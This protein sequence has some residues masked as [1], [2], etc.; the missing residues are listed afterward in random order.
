MRFTKVD[1]TCPNTTSLEVDSNLGASGPSALLTLTARVWARGLRGL[2]LGC[3]SRVPLSREAGARLAPN[4]LPSAA[5][6]SSAGLPA[7]R[8]HG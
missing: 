3:L 6:F 7:Q 8:R 5:S 1:Q 4:P 2:R